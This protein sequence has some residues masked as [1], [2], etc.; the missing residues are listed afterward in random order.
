MAY[1]MAPIPMTL[2][3]FEGYICWYEWQN[4]PVRLHR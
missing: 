4:A 2:S 3:K 1:R